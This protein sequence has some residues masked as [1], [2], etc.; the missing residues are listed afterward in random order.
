MIKKCLLYMKERHYGRIIICAS[1]AG[2]RYTPR[3]CGYGMAKAAI[4]NLTRTCAVELGQYDIVTNCFPPV[5][6]ASHFEKQS[7]DAALAVPIMNAF[8][9]VG[10]MGDAYEDDSPMLAFLACEEARYINGQIISICGG[11]SYISPNTVLEK[12]AQF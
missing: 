6:Q 9:P 2:E 3:S 4:I 12:M 7:N 8:D 5:I 11:I 10:R 1:G